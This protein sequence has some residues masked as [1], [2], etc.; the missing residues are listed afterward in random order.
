M[1][2]VNVNKGFSS[3]GLDTH[4]IFAQVLSLQN[5]A[6]IISKFVKFTPTPHKVTAQ[7]VWS[8]NDSNL[9][10]KLNFS[11][12]AGR[13]SWNTQTAIFSDKDKLKG[14]NATIQII[15]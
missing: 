10:L 3:S 15:C 13:R 7:S 14:T 5:W 4:P 6:R 12:A 9:D 2:C 1:N 8:L 11:G